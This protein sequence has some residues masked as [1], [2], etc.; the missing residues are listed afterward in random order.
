MNQTGGHVGF[1]LFQVAAGIVGFLVANLAVDLEHAFN[2][3]VDLKENL[4]LSKE[5]L[6]ECVELDI[7]LEVEAG[8][9]GG[10]VDR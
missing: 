7:I 8:C 4:E 10:E 6:K 9:V 5:L 3:L 2:V 1:G